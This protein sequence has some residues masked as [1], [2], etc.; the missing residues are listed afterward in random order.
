[1]PQYTITLTNDKIRLYDRFAVFMLVINAAAITAILTLKKQ[2]VLQQGSGL[3]TLLFLLAALLVYINTS[4]KDK[5]NLFFFLA[6][7][8]TVLYWVLTGFWWA[9]VVSA[10]LAALYK[11]A[12][13]IP[14]VTVDSNQVSYPSFPTRALPWSSLHNIVLK[15][16]LLTIDLKNNRLIQQP[17]D[18]KITTINEQVFNEFC[19]QQLHKNKGS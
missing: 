3:L 8:F 16:G 18:E 10:V 15:D 4:W 7:V 9:A 6:A 14:V 17:V 13:K 12:G 1:M 19:F 5:W 2:T 11:Y